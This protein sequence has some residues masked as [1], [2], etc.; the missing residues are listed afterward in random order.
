MNK[1][2]EFVRLTACPVEPIHEQLH[3]EIS[4][5]YYIKIFSNCKKNKSLKLSLQY[6]VVCQ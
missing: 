1:L 4:R 2:P 6:F 3:A 5:N